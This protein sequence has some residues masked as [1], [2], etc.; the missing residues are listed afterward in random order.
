VKKLIGAFAAL[1]LLA[2][3]IPS[4]VASPACGNYPQFNG[5]RNNGGSDLLGFQC[6]Q[7]T[8]VGWDDD[9]G[10]SYD[11]FRGSDNDALSSFRFYGRTGETWCI[12]L[13]AN[14]GRLGSGDY[15]TYR[16]YNGATVYV[17]SM[18]SGWN[19]RVSSIEFYSRSTIGARC[20]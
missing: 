5:F 2:A 14:A 6:P 4:A 18:P 11:G 20:P 13:F 15:I 9:F 16:S 12:L 1:A 10:D 8:T 7:F 3:L 19:D 17:S